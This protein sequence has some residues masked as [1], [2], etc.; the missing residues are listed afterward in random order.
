[1]NKHLKLKLLRGHFP[2]GSKYIFVITC[3]HTCSSKPAELSRSF[4]KQTV[5]LRDFTL[6]VRFRL[7][8]ALFN[9]SKTGRFVPLL[10]SQT[11]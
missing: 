5:F 2:V 3:Y 6:F 8:C 1:M 7:H 4:S 10:C 11:A 9:F